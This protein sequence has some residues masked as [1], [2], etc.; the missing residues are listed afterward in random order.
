MIFDPTFLA[1]LASHSAEANRDAR[2]RT[3]TTSRLLGTIKPAG[4]SAQ[5]LVV[6]AATPDR[7]WS[8]GEIAARMPDRKSLSW[9]LRQCQLMG[10]VE[11]TSDPRSARY[12]RYR[13]SGD[14]M[15]MFE[16]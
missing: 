7:F 5:L 4:A 14:G 11:S 16:P 12:M 3:R 2:S 8:H 10:W 13:I 9:A 6:L 1:Q 15:R